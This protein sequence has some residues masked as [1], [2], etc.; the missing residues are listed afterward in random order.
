MSIPLRLIL[1]CG[2]EILKTTISQSV[3]KCDVDTFLRCI[4]HAF[5]VKDF[6]AGLVFVL[7]VVLEANDFEAR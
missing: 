7:N 1:L 2:I 3:I 5:L 4:N 6:T